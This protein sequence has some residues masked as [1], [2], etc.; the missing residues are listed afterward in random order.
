MEVR[1]WEGKKER[2]KK[3]K[4]EEEKRI[5]GYP[6]CMWV[7]RSSAGG[8]HQGIWAGAICSKS[9]KMPKKEIVAKALDGQR[10][11]LPLIMFVYASVMVREAAAPKWL[12]TYAE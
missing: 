1:C 4:E 10:Y 2:E 5:H 9:S 11:P 7:G 8:G 6:S 12:M 3:R